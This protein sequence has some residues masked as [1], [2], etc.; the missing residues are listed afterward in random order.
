MNLEKSFLI[1][2]RQL[3]HLGVKVDFPTASVRPTLNKSVPVA[4]EAA[5]VASSSSVTLP[6]LESLLEKLV[7]LEKVFRFGRLH[8]RA[9][10]SFL[11]HELLE[12]VFSGGLFLSRRSY[13]VE[14]SDS[15]TSMGPS[16]SAQ[17]DAHRVYRC[18]DSR[19]GCLL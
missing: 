8:L 4:V 17:T 15:P 14:R 2:R 16:P 5:S 19:L 9:L 10:P 3:V 1:P 18:I 7:A 12:V 11:L 6:R 13:F